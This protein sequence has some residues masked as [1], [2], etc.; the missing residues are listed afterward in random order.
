MKL[1][2]SYKKI[3]LSALAV[4]T[5]IP[6]FPATGYFTGNGGQG[7]TILIYKSVLE[8]G[9]SDKSDEWISNKIKLDILNDLV[10]YS[11][12]TVIDAAEK[13][14]I[15]KIQ[16]EYE[17]SEYSEEN[18]I[19][20][21][22]SLQAK[23]YITITT[24]RTASSGESKYTANVQITNIE[25][26]KT[27]G[28]Y[29]LSKS[30]S[31]SE[32]ITKHGIISAE[33]LTQ[34]GVNLTSAGKRLIQYGTFESE[35][36]LNLSDYEE[37]LSAINA[38]IAKLNAEESKL[39]AQ[40]L[41]SLEAEAEKAR[42][43][44][45]KAILAQQQKNEQERIERLKS[46]AQREQEEMLAQ[47]DRDIE[48]QMEIMRLS[49]EIEKKAMEIKAKKSESLTASQQIEVIE[50]EKQIL[51]SN[52]KSVQDAI[53]EYS[54]RLKAEC[55]NEISQR[56]NQQPQK[57]HLAS[58]GVSLNESGKEFL[59]NDI[60]AITAKYNDLIDT[61]TAEI[62]KE[63]E[64]AQNQ[65]REKITSDISKLESKTFTAD[66]ILNQGLYLRINNYDGTKG[67]EGWRYTLTF[68]FRGQNI[69]VHTDILNYT[70]ITGKKIPELPK[71]EDKNYKTKRKVY[72]EYLDTVD[73]YDSFFRLNVPYIES[74]ITYTI[75]AGSY[76]EASTYKV[77]IKSIDFLNVES[78]KKIKTLSA[79]ETV[80]YAFTPS[81]KVDWRTQTQK[82]NDYKAQAKAE[83][84]AQEKAQ[85]KIKK[86][87]AKN[88][89]STST[90]SSSSSSSKQDARDTFSS[91]IYEFLPGTISYYR[92]ADESFFTIGYLG[93]IGIT[94]NIFCGLT[95]ELGFGGNDIFWNSS[96][97]YDSEKD[98]EAIFFTG[99]TGLFGLSFN[100]FTN[101]RLSIYAEGGY[102]GTGAGG[103]VG[104]SMEIYA[105]NAVGIIG[106]LG[107]LGNSNDLFT[108][109]SVGFE[110]CF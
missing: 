86:E 81:V 46:D 56:K 97:S 2:N 47:N 105:P 24:T 50:G 3:I 27:E 78:G 64:S 7:K 55:E 91:L 109:Y 88:K 23:Y 106:S 103:G 84:E 48:K 82:N 71:L 80:T 36:K 31:E 38:E 49:N 30:Y 44:T 94:N 98:S 63:T 62:R 12:L 40:N 51:Y 59:N 18:P 87:N 42:I 16:K 101:F 43:E 57:A 28:G 20:L 93:T 32:Y 41:T 96:N 5:A 9:K 83:R 10:N 110:V 85:A 66:S 58:D 73:N 14:N 22:K 11:N 92:S 68:S 4:F 60:N 29:N 102:I 19:Q 65:L 76:K 45:Q 108:K 33:I 21:G 61:N 89:K 34:L 90:Q 6:L 17:S 104:A 1:F 53:D 39:T 52:E 25:T 77:S 74:K 54:A 69:F 99:L 67:K 70:E 13:E 79:S 15:R 26:R 100:V 95:A 35:E 37:N 72:Q 8:N 75:K 107:I